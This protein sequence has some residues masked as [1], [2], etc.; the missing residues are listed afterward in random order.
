MSCFL[1]SSYFYICFAQYCQLF[2]SEC[3][4][5]TTAFYSSSMDSFSANVNDAVFSIRQLSSIGFYFVASMSTIVTDIAVNISNAVCAA[6]TFINDIA[7]SVSR[8]FGMFFCPK[9]VR[10]KR[11]HLRRNEIFSIEWRLRRKLLTRRRPPTYMRRK[12]LNDTESQTRR[13]EHIHRKHLIG[14]V[15]R[16]RRKL[17][18]R[19][20]TPTKFFDPSA[21]AV[22]KVS[23]WHTWNKSSGNI[24]GHRFFD[25]Q[26]CVILGRGNSKG[27]LLIRLSSSGLKVSI[28]KFYISCD[29][30]SIFDEFLFGTVSSSVVDLILLF[31]SSLSSQCASIQVEY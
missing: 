9:K 16:L 17:L 4:R 6:L 18:A 3:A 25:D 26:Q 1:E 20:R 28:S 22:D 14:T 8:A 13:K 5:D 23:I 7:T 31:F 24:H 15:F 19:G 10:K 11:M 30:S 12:H 27:Q 21:S 29:N 2:N